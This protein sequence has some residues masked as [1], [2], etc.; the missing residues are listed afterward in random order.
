MST[1]ST[2]WFD[3]NNDYDQH[4]HDIGDRITKHGAHDDAVEELVCFGDF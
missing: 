4:R 3:K 2:V 1:L